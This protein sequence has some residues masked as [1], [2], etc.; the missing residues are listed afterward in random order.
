MK[1]S[2]EDASTALNTYIKILLYLKW[3]SYVKLPVK[4]LSW[5]HTQKAENRN[6]KFY[7]KILCLLILTSQA[8]GYI[9]RMSLNNSSDVTEEPAR[10]TK[11]SQ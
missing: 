3:P 8:T 7:F 4:K 1:I 6:M 11:K 2:N 10:D 9:K 5:S